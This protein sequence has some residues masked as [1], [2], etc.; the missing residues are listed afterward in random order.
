M[1]K[2]RNLVMAVYSHPEYL[3]PTLNA[4]EFL[5]RDFDHIYVVH[6]NV[7][8]FDWKYPAN[9][10]LLK[11]GPG[12]PVKE[13][14]AKP[15]YTKVLYF[16]RFAWL[17]AKTI[18]RSKARVVLLYDYMPIL[19]YRISGWVFK[20]PSVL[21]F[22]SHDVAEAQYLRKWSLSWFGWQSEKWIFPKLT[23]FSLPAVERKICFP[24]DTLKG[25]FFFIPNFPARLVY[26]KYMVAPKKI[27]D[28]VRILYQGMI[29]ELHGLEEIIEVL[30]EKI[31]GKNLNLVLKGFIS[32]EY[33]QRLIGLS[34]ANGVSDK[35]IFV[36]P[37]GYEG[38]IKN[39][40]T[41]HIGIGIHKKKDLMNTT[42]GTASNKIY[43]YAASG[44]P[45]L[46]YDNDHFRQ[47][48]KG[49]EWAFFTDTSGTSLKEQFAAI[50][51]NYD[52]LSQKALQDFRNELCFEKAFFP[53]VEELNKER[54]AS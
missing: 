26:E 21:W 41:C 13:S 43:E 24:M 11:S 35:L 42:L 6:R 25:I 36:G 53:V 7:D 38:V 1:K 15:V 45:V 47:S 32:E 31:A 34:E 27:D 44:M 9:V 19:A 14:E 46:L 33:K 40:I 54:I 39:A 20:R 50:L 48:L 4:I 37:S 5:S 52:S 3:P 16:L 22:H 28:T 2:A 23:F 30:S 12:M 10:I 49:R 29:G 8:G 18:R 51:A 17:L